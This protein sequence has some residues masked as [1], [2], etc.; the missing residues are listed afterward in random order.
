M[1]PRSIWFGLIYFH[2]WFWGK[3]KNHATASIFLKFCSIIGHNY[4]KFRGPVSFSSPKQSPICLTVIRTLGQTGLS[5]SPLSNM[6]PHVCICSVHVL[7]KKSKHNNLKG[8]WVE[9]HL[10]TMKGGISLWSGGVWKQ[11]LVRNVQLFLPFLYTFLNTYK[12]KS[13]ICP[14]PSKKKL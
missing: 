11:A 5:G 10:A 7:N 12:T 1:L 6:A 4:F 8:S 2:E 9:V 14:P 13:P 3:F